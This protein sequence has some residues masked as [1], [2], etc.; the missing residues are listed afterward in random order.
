M[1][2]IRA[3]M[4]A[5]AVMQSAYGIA[6][7]RRIEP[8]AAPAA[9]APVAADGTTLGRLFYTPAQRA[10]LDE[11]RRR[12]QRVAQ[13]EKTP[14]PPTPEYV[15]LNGIV[16]RSDGTT[17][18]WL[19]DKQVRG[20]ESEEGLQIAP[21]RR[22]G[23]PSSVTVRVPQTG[24][25]VDLKVGQ[26]L[27]VNSGEVKE[28]Y[29]APQRESAA[30]IAQAPSP[31][32]QQETPS[33]RD[34]RAARD[35]DALRDLLREIEGPPSSSNGAADKPGASSVPAERGASQPR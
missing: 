9:S 17:T 21:S 1:K 7:E 31:A 34:R 12:P 3:T 11:L 15:T 6:A 14:L 30:P 8:P 16:R 23:A 10:T 28:A 19:N 4:L 13:D 22:A 25:T 32:P 18:V 20:R 35:R 5:A 33:P 27:E 26:Q 24:R 29:R 2:A